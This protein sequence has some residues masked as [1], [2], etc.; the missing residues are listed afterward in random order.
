MYRI[1]GKLSPVKTF[2][3]FAVSEQITK[4][5]TEK[6]FIKYSGIIINGCVVILDHGDRVGIMD[7]AFLSL[8]RQYLSNSS[9]PNHHVDMVASIK[10]RH[11]VDL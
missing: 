7:V 6:M 10:G 8:A 1:S 9:F 5:L 3:N 4:V 11:F 2:T